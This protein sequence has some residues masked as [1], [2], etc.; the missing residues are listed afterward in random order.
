M[1][2][3][4]TELAENFMTAP[5][6]NV[7]TTFAKLVIKNRLGLHARAAGKLVEA[8]QPFKSEIILARDDCQAD[9][10][11]ILSLISLGCP[12]NTEVTLTASG[13]DAD[14]AVAAVAA[15]IENRFGET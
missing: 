11:S 7:P 2:E 14:E 12:Y 5:F 3:V 9:V 4:E 13:E 10:R 8:A 15:I 1:D 6:D